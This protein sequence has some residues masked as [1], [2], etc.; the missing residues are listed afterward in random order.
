MNGFRPGSAKVTPSYGVG[1]AN[2]GAG[3]QQGGGGWWCSGGGGTYPPAGVEAPELAELQA[4]ASRATR[5]RDRS[6][7]RMAHSSQ[8][9]QGWALLPS[10]KAGPAAPQVPVGADER[11]P[12]GRSRDAGSV[13]GV[14]VLGQERPQLAENPRRGAPDVKTT[15]PVAA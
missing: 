8:G 3:S 12:A 9:R 1:A 14:P 10:H 11:S 6:G 5:P 4:A 15:D 2:D 13:R 7:L